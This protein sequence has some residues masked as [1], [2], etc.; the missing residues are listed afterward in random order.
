MMSNEIKPTSGTHIIAFIRSRFLYENSKK[1]PNIENEVMFNGDLFA[2]T[3]KLI[4]CTTEN[5][6]EFGLD[7]HLEHIKEISDRII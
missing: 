4:H 1:S 6:V 2:M 7:Q 3:G 5:S